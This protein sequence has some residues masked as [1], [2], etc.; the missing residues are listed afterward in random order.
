MEHQNYYHPFVLQCTIHSFIHSW[1]RSKIYIN[2]LLIR[3]CGDYKLVYK[4]DR[5]NF[6]G[7]SL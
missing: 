7:L 3:E 6:A 5:F 1:G 4:V 2:N